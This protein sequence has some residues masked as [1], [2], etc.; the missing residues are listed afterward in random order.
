MKK[1]GTDMGL[2][3]NQLAR[4]AFAVVI[5]GLALAWPAAA[6]AGTVYVNAATGNNAWSGWCQTWD[7]ATC[8]PKKTI[9][10]GINIA[11]AGDT[12][13]VADGT[14]T[15]T[16]NKNLDFGGKPITVQS[17]SGN[18]AAC[19]I[20]CQGSGRGFY[21][22]T[23]ETAASAVD[24]FT[25]GN[26]SQD[27]V[28]CVSTYPTLTHCTISGNA[29]QGVNC[30]AAVP[31]LTNC[32]I[33]GN[34]GAGVYLYYAYSG[35]APPAQLLNCTISGN[36][37]GGVYCRYASLT[38]IN[39]TISGN[40]RGG[41]WW[42]DCNPT[43]TDC[44]ISGN[45][46]SSTT[47][48]SSVYGGGAVLGSGSR[49][50]L[51]NCTISGNTVWST[52][53]DAG[54]GGVF[55]GNANPTLINCTIRRNVALSLNGNASGGGVSCSSGTGSLTNCTISENTVSSAGSSGYGGAVYCGYA[56]T[57]TLTNCTINGNTA[58]SAGGAVYCAIYSSPKLTN[59]VFW[60][61]A[62]QEVSVYSG[63]TPAVTYCDVEGGYAGTGNLNVDPGFAFPGDFHLTAGSPCID[64]G[65]NAPPGGLPAR[66]ADG[67]LRPLDGNGDDQAV[68]DMG[69]YEFN[70]TVPAIALSMTRV[71]F[72]VLEGQVNPESQSLLIRNAGGA[73][74][75][76]TLAWDAPWLHADV[77]QGESSGE[78]D[79]VMLLPDVSSLS[80]GVYSTTMTASDPQASNNPRFVQVVLY[81]NKTLRVPSDYP[82][83]QA[84]IDAAAVPA[85]QVV[86]ADG[87]YTGP[88][89]KD[90]EFGGKALTVR[91]AS[92][93]PAA[94][95]IDCQGSGRGFYFHRGETA[96]S[97]VAGLTI[98]NGYVTDAAPGSA[99]GGA[100]FCDSSSPT[101][102][103]CVISTNAA[104]SAASS[105]YGGA[106]YCANQADTSLI[107][108]TISANSA[109]APKSYAYGG[110]VCALFSSPTLTRCV[111]SANTVSSASSPY[112]AYGGGAYCSGSTSRMT[113]TACTL[114]Q[115]SATNGAGVYFYNS[116]PML[117][118]CTVSGNTASLGGG[119]VYC[120]GANVTLTD[121]ALSQN[122]AVAGGGIYCDYYSDTTLTGCTVGGN[123]V[124]ANGA[125][126]Y[127]FLSG[128]TFTSCTISGNTAFST[129]SQT[130]GGGVYCTSAASSVLV[131]C[132]LSGN[133]ASSTSSSASGAA[134]SCRYSSPTL[135][136]CTIS[137]NRA[138]SS[139][140][141]A[142]GGGMS[143]YYSSPTLTNCTISGNTASCAYGAYGGGVLCNASSPS[144]SNC[145]LTGN[146]AI[147]NL[148]P[149][150]GGVY[151][152]YSSN[153]NL[154]NCIL[155]ADTPQEILVDSGAPTVR[156]SDVQGGCAGTGNLNLNPLFVNAVGGDFHLGPLSPCIDAGDP[157]SDFSLEPEPDGG[158]INMGAYG[159]TPEAET[160][161]WIYIDAYHIARK[162]RVGRTLF[163]YDLTTTVRNAS[164]QGVTNV[165]ATLLAAPTNVQIIDGVVNVGSL[166]AGSTVESADTFTIQV[167]RSTLV[168]PLPISW[169]VTYGSGFAEFTTLLELGPPRLPGDVNCDGRV[170]FDDINP[171]VLALTGADGYYTEYPECDWLNAD[172][173]GDG[174]VDFDDINA[175]VALLTQ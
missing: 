39:C 65:T 103:N 116:V 109:A 154:T 49:P 68:G 174:L 146:R 34:S 101:L 134:L 30:S 106:V 128:F 167:D 107:D 41:F 93:N 73:T 97:V 112:N 48:S 85:D 148:S 70:P 120:Y 12:V 172:C 17:A 160:K 37:N 19:I 155:W 6:T 145:T 157:A 80:H 43:L 51:T 60:G 150:G 151:S 102:S 72:H 161:G 7:G 82:T 105:A 138:S 11:V 10:A 136:N 3:K 4:A 94:C 47:P 140:Y 29:G 139:T 75:R 40:T 124:S 171:F 92:G 27:G 121:C 81:L 169:R 104:S 1:V 14:Y 125:G 165:V 16:G 96:A 166:P 115:N 18:P 44:T 83:I 59:C 53:S 131:N 62:P 67:N 110:G 36:A 173:N 168:S 8:G 137:G 126:V 57:P 118:N 78:V 142:G 113:L 58:T 42:N 64:A 135:T 130:S 66:D 79:A 55:F 164:S 20:D 175:F 46:V 23:N 22:H 61:D 127:C 15:G 54:G 90:L 156:Y 5:C 52:T 25:I 149:A 129:S 26:G 28:Y 77:T 100:V 147:S 50:T 21:F 45:V 108:C 76:W 69:A 33:S 152:S 87:V 98:R 71:E 88:G 91:S 143:C 38:L 86:V 111:I 95:I 119:G 13:I 122:L 163:E 117:T 24:G 32:T 159:N 63:S 153:P 99:N 84:A 162:T 132:T 170:D 31:K 114:M 123:S 133:T 2:R 144:L 35:S 158:R 89:N 141:S 74:L 9:Q 56:S